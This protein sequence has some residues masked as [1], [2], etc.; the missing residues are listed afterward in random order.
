MIVLDT[1]VISE[2]NKE[3][4][5]R[6]VLSWFAEHDPLAVFLTDVTMMEIVY[7]AER[8]LIKHRSDRY[9]RF[10]NGVRPNSSGGFWGSTAMLSPLRAVSAPSVR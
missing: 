1:N 10:S 6:P 4:P 9:Y 5:D 2:V 3:R 8:H 7:G